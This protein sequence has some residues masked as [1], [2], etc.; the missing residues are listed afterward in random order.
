M[1]NKTLSLITVSYASSDYV[2]RCIVSLSRELERERISYEWILVNNDT[3]DTIFFENSVQRKYHI[4]LLSHPYGNIG[5]GRACNLAEKQARG[6]Y[7]WFVN[8]DMRYKQGNVHNALHFFSSHKASVLGF[9]LLN[10]KGHIHSWIFGSSL[11]MVS[12]IIRY[13][14]F[15]S[16]IVSDPQK[17]KKVDWVSGASLLVR[18]DIF[19][20]IQGF[21]E[22]FFLY[23]EDRDICF[24]IQKKYPKTCWYYP[25]V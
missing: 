2:M 23:F 11:H 21:D 16:G 24:R 18:K 4:H 14:L 7:L 5:F 15:L 3:Q 20:S 25:G 12:W 6:K 19:R 13:L 17:P 10:T 22:D 8:P 1:K 9:R